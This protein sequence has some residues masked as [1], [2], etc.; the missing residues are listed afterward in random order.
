MFDSV[1][2]KYGTFINCCRYE[3]N[4]LLM[5]YTNGYSCFIYWYII[6][7]SC[8]VILT[9]V[10]CNEPTETTIETSVK[11]SYRR[12]MLLDEIVSMSTFPEWYILKEPDFSWFHL[13]NFSG[14]T[15]SRHTHIG[16]PLCHITDII[17]SMPHDVCS[18]VLHRP[19]AINNFVLKS[20]S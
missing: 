17:L 14:I 8:C 16:E 3:F 6:Q 20:N 1:I 13:Q 19:G 4:F 18:I 5:W 11:H 2:A 10:L 9:W 12:V 7:C 15:I